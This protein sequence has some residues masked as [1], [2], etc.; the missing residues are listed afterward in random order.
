MLGFAGIEPR[1]PRRYPIESHVAETL[2]VRT[3]FEQTFGFRVGQPL[4]GGQE[5]S[6]RFTRAPNGGGHAGQAL[7][8]YVT[9]RTAGRV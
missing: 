8:G 2:H 1:K 9:D 5:E 7:P 3:A 4:A 6:H